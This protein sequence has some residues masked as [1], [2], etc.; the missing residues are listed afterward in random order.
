MAVIGDYGNRL[1][2][3][4]RQH[5]LNR[6]APVRLEGNPLANP[7]LEHVCVGADVLQVIK[8]MGYDHRIGAAFLN[9]GL[10]YGGSCFPKDSSALLRTAEKQAE[11]LASVEDQLLS[12]IEEKI[13][14]REPLTK[15]AV[16]AGCAITAAM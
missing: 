4:A 6:A 16:K 13:E 14:K 7:E 15:R 11:K 1:A 8:G 3:V 12:V 9:A 10:G 5:A 2:I